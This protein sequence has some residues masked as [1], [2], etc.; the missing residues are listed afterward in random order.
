MVPSDDPRLVILV[1]VDEPTKEL[2][3]ARVAAPVFAK[4]ADF[5]LRRLGVAPTM[6]Q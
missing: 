3:G 1:M 4:I 5:A 6:S 2:S